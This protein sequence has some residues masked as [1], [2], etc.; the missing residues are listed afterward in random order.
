MR[1]LLLYFYFHYTLSYTINQTLSDFLKILKKLTSY[2]KE[3]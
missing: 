3:L 1:L 2:K